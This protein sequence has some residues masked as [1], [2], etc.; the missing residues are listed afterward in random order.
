MNRQ[1]LDQ[2]V[3]A[4]APGAR[5][6][7]SWILEGGVAADVRALE[8]ELAGGAI[9]RH[10][11]RQRRPLEWKIGPVDIA[12]EFAVLEALHARGLPVPEPQWLDAAGT[13][14]D[15]PGF[16]MS[17]VN[18]TTMTDAFEDRP[19]TD[20]VLDQLAAFLAMVHGLD[21]AT[22]PPLPLRVDPVPELL[23][24]L[25]EGRLRQT[26]AT[27][28]VFRSTVA[29]TSLLHGDYWAGNV[30]WHDDRISA[31]LDWEDAALGDPLSDLSGARLELLWRYG[32]ESMERFTT[33]YLTLRPCDTSRLPLWDLYVGTA[34]MDSVAQWGLA[35]EAEAQMRD[36]T[37]HILA[38]AERAVLSLAGAGR[39]ES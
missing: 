35:P 39:S 18:G 31:V 5:P 33:R 10:V 36:Q 7:R 25:P 34:A 12:T 21:R 19:L 27:T 23:E 30:L 8:I 32:P 38:S 14:L 13:V 16:V 20:D 1:P 24:W 17:F 26:L 11:L 4:F 28:D 6:L 22:L 9:T 15:A 3:A 2:V 29:A 37:A